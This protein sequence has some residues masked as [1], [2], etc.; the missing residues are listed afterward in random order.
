MLSIAGSDSSGGAGIQADIK[1]MMV[2]GVFAMTAVTA[3]TAQNTMGVTAV[4]PVTPELLAAQIDAV[5][6]DIPPLAVKIGMLPN[7]TLIDV[8][9]ERLQAHHA[10]NVVVDTVMIASSGARLID[11]DA[12]AAMASRLFPIATLITPNLPE[13]AVLLGEDDGYVHGHRAM[14]RAAATLE[15]RYGCSVLVKGGH[16]GT[17]ADDV[18]VCQGVGTWFAGAHIATANTHGTGCTLSSAIASFLARK[19]ALP[20]AVADAKAYLTGALLAGLDLGHG[21]G[22]MDHGWRWRHRPGTTPLPDTHQEDGN[23]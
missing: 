17:D 23:R 10:D 9:A 8:V 22:P 14:Q 20:D 16:S 11:R 6:E 2:C 7:R 4:A 3:L 5:F 19:E 18:L 12:T 1:T 13:A 15:Q 21:S